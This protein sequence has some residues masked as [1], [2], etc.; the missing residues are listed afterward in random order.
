VPLI[1]TQSL[2]SR[3]QIPDILSPPE[4]NALNRRRYRLSSWTVWIICFVAVVFYMARVPKDRVA[5][6]VEQS[7][8]HEQ[9][10]SVTIGTGDFG[11]GHEGTLAFVLKSCKGT[12]KAMTCSLTVASPGYDRVLFFPALKTTITDAHGNVFLAVTSTPVIVLSG[13][14]ARPFNMIFRLDKMPVLPGKMVLTGYVDNLLV[15]A[16]FE[17]K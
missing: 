11:K 3:R 14:A 10:A 1:A 15:F 13:G 8:Q 4:E 5:G 2:R 6:H 16:N 9:T 12:D 17:V 7:T